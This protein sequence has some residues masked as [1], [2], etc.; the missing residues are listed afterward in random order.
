MASSKTEAVKVEQ[1]STVAIPE[2]LQ[3]GTVLVVGGCG[4]LGH[5][6]VKFLLAEPTCTA[7]VVMSRSPFQN[8]FEG[9]THH[10]GDITKL[11]HVKHVISQVKPKV[12][13]DT[14]SPHAYSD[15]E[16]AHDN[17]TVN[18]DGVQHLL[19]VA[20]KVGTVKAFVYTS[21]GPIIAGSGGGYDHAD[22]TTPTLAVTKKGDPYHVAKALGDKLT[23]EANGKNAGILTACIRPTALYGEGD[24]QMVGPVI[25]VIEDGQ[26]NIWMGY[27]D[28]HMDVVYVGHVAKAEVLAALG[29][30][31]RHVDK[32]APKIDGEAFN[33]TDDETCPPWTFFRKYWML[34]GDKTSLS[35]V[36][37]I[38]PFV[39][40]LMANAA[41]WFTWAT[42][43]G[44][45]RPKILKLE[46][47]EFV[48]FTR[49]YNINKA[50]TLLGFQP[51]LDIMV[52]GLTKYT[53][54]TSKDAYNG[55]E[56]LKL[57]EELAIPYEEHMH[58]EIQTILDLH[59]KIASADLANIDKLMRIQA[60]KYSDIFKIGPLYFGCQDTHFSIDE[61]HSYYPHVNPASISFINHVLARRHKA[62]WRFCPSD[63][64]GQPRPLPETGKDPVKAEGKPKAIGEM[65]IGKSQ[66]GKI[67]LL[68]MSLLSACLTAFWLA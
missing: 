62:L 42:S 36:W 66:W 67:A 57:I 31:R 28:V 8:R 21:S 33:I 39:V 38:P 27:N 1:P 11:S 25:K 46:R 47:M 41:E 35:G 10:I 45:A 60:E 44:K 7:V 14:A 30:L 13:I 37:M 17:F 12:I 32:T 52:H 58:A 55:Y 19:D 51:W 2:E 3:L 65:V 49:T 48:L 63:M 54:A 43:M 68:L 53:E 5:H 6:V 16:H 20:A 18:V 29:L 24:T 15:H 40:L 50:R 34:A 59:T 64:F 9:V 26:T 4:F 23:L 56:L 22:E 61:Q